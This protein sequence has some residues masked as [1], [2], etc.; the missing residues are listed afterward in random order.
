VAL[1]PVGD[2]A[3]LLRHAEIAM[4]RAKEDGRDRTV[5]F[6]EELRDVTTD[7]LGLLADLR[8]AVARGEL[9]LHY[10]PIVA[11]DGQRVEGV[12][13]LVRWEHPQ[14]GLVPPDEFISLAENRGLIVDIGR[15]VL[16][17]ACRQAALWVNAGPDGKPLHMAVNVSALQLASG[18]GLVDS[19][20]AVLRDSGVDP[21]VLVL[22]ITETALMGNPEAAL[23]ILTRLKA[24]GVN[25]AI[26]DFGTGYSSLV[27][28]KRFP[29]DL[30]KVDR[31]F[32][33]GLGQ[34]QEDS[35]IVA[36]VV[37]LARA[38]GVVAV[39]EGVET[40]EQLVALQELG[41]EFA[42]GYLWSRPL[43]PAELEQAVLINN[44]TPD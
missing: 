25:L 28:L 13:A 43:P 10:Q 42:Q 29:V 18:A 14:R 36:S 39:A 5:L 2:P 34:N 9:R 21:S 35:A 38:V 17:E 40:I 20:A 8:H 12:E 27:Y 30:L 33:S 6:D 32:I 37:G 1:T 7:R 15:W 23:E 3:I 16:R 11:L 4:A 22:E 19:V 26:D 24:L 44:R 31:S 41:C